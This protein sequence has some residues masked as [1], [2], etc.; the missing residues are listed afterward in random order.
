MWLPLVVAVLRTAGA[1]PNDGH[2]EKFKVLQTRTRS[3]T[4]V[5][6]TTRADSY[7]FILHSGGMEN[8]Q[9]SELPPEVRKTRLCS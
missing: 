2:E 3:Y 4:N 5:T 6:V 1:A 8:V 7:I 9:L